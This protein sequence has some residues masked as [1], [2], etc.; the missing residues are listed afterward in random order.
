MQAGLMLKNGQLHYSFISNVSIN[1]ILNIIAI[2]NLM[3]TDD[4]S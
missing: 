4:R 2:A 1:F 3:R